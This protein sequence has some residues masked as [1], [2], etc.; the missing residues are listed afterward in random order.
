DQ[1][2]ARALGVSTASLSQILQSALTGSHVSFFRE[3]NELIEI[4][5]RGTEQERRDLS[6]LPS[7]AVPT[8][9][10][11]SVALSQI[12][13]LEYGFEEGINWHRNRLPTVT[14]RADN[15]D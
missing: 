14:V 15:Y 11:R 2:R 1:E 4:L 12:A 7:L 13:T 6:L 3:D 9:N 8:D 5:L 10:G